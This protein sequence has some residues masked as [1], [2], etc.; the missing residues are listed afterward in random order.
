M[1]A[2]LEQKLQNVNLSFAEWTVLAFTSGAPLKSDDVVQRQITGHII[3]AAADGHESI[4]RLTRAGL[5]AKNQDDVLAHTESGKAV[6]IRLSGEVE[7]MT[8]RLYGDL[9][10]EDLQ[11]THRTLTEIAK[12]AGTLLGRQS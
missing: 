12:R 2:L 6:F 4:G 7:G 9:P 8:Q 11:A 10:I 1:R 5:I 3:A